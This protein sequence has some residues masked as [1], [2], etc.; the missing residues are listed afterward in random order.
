MVG[1]GGGGGD[2]DDGELPLH[3][4]RTQRISARTPNSSAPFVNK[5]ARSANQEIA[6]DL[7]ALKRATIVGEATGGGAHPV[8]PRKLDDW[9]T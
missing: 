7:Q 5:G 6:Y 9:F 1:G 8:G 3:A 2:P 4:T